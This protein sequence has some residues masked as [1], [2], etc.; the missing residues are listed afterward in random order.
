MTR[1]EGRSTSKDLESGGR[2]ACGEHGV[3][4][5]SVPKADWNRHLGGPLG[6]LYKRTGD[7]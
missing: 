5:G 4:E 6:A 2:G 1:A 7:T 3:G